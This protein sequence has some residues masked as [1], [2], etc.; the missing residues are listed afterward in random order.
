MSIVECTI[1]AKNASN[2]YKRI[3]NL[4]FNKK[5]TLIAYFNKRIKN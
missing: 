1:K 5:N 2:K 3:L 4:V